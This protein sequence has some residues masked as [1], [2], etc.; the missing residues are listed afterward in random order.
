M[1]SGIDVIHR[2]YIGIF[3][4]GLILYIVFVPIGINSAKIIGSDV[5]TS[6][7]GDDDEVTSVSS[8]TDDLIFVIN[9]E[10]NLFTE[11]FYNWSSDFA[12]SI[13]RDPIVQRS[14]QDGSSLVN[15][16]SQGSQL[17]DAYLSRLYPVLTL[18]NLST[19]ILIQGTNLFLDLWE[20]N[21]HSNNSL[22]I[23]YNDSKSE[24]STSLP[25]LSGGVLFDKTA[26]AWLDQLREYLTPFNFSSN[27]KEQ[28]IESW[29]INPNYWL[30]AIDSS[31][32]IIFETY[33]Q[34]IQTT[35][36]WSTDFVFSTLSLLLFGTQSSDILAF[37]IELFD[38]GN[39][40]S[41]IRILKS[42]ILDFLRGEYIPYGLPD[43]ILRF[44]LTTFTNSN[45]TSQPTSMIYRIRLRGDMNQ[46]ELEL[47]LNHAEKI[48]LT[49]SR[50]NNLDLEVIVLSQLKYLLDRSDNLNDEFHRLDLIVFVLG[51]MILL[52]W[53]EDLLA[54]VI[55]LSLSWLTTQVGKGIIVTTLPNFITMIDSSLTM[56]S[57]VMLGA[58]LN[59]S[60]FFTIRYQ[61]EMK[62]GDQQKAIIKA[63]QTAIH[64]IL[65]S[66]FALFLVFI[67]LVSS[68]VGIISGLAWTS[69][70][71]V[72]LELICLAIFLPTVFLTLKS[73]L[74][75]I[76]LPRRK[77]RKISFKVNYLNYKKIIAVFFILAFISSLFVATN[78]STFVANDIIGD[79]GQTG[80][81]LKLLEEDYPS[82]FLNK[83]LIRLNLTSNL[84]VNKKIDLELLSQISVLSD[85]INISDGIQDIISASQ[86]YGKQFD[87]SND[88]I[89]IVHYETALLMTNQ[90][91]DTSTNQTF[92]VVVFS[93][94]ISDAEVLTITNDIIVEVKNYVDSVE[95]ITNSKI[96]GLPA[97]TYGLSKRIYTELPLQILTS[98]I[99][100][101][102]FLWF[103]FRS[104]SVPLRLEITII[105][106]SLLAQGIATLIWL[107]L[108]EEGF[109]LIIN[110]ISLVIL[111]GL[112]I[113]FDIYIYNR[114]MEEFKL[115]KNLLDSI[116][117]ALDKSAP[118]IRTSGFVMAISFLSLLISDLR[119]VRQFGLITF[120]A[121][122][123][124]VLIIRTLLVPAILLLQ[125]NHGKTSNKL[126]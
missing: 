63:T 7:L 20:I 1:I 37:F 38:G 108:F 114:I 18:A 30:K 95:V 54:I 2:G 92:I 126:R 73:A 124:D 120:I 102:A 80:K 32:H 84:L 105:I 15:I 85:R 13:E 96:S 58:A 41:P 98:V 12:L 117:I 9:S 67:P 61:E 42:R 27:I 31:F 52:I 87:F 16:F 53:I 76:M 35:T 68:S 100:L 43:Q 40:Q 112:G 79:Q 49:F 65:I 125:S 44:Y 94:Q 62:K 45:G 111:L 26:I 101:T 55:S 104:L 109:N 122:L 115:S 47:I 59:Y 11:E 33:L 56:G 23:A 93:D 29:R 66:G 106:G 82:N 78:S 70:V 86:P 88:S 113:D 39:A 57:T 71:G 3:L 77:V 116:E 90:L 17:L 28:I 8:L 74:G 64:S 51:F 107:I 48:A 91:I 10:T 24:L 19:F 103:Q 46:S 75:K 25:K 21:L 81:A 123:I 6:Q 4:V 69:A 36:P 97:E 14:V 119:V 50:S 5:R 83:L 72:L 60:V 121:I 99:L 89:G 22:E 110:T 118:A 34:T